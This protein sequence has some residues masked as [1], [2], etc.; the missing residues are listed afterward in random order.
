MS[1][2]VP[3]VLPKNREDLENKLERF[4]AIPSVTRIQIDVVDG[5]FATPKS[6]PYTESRALE[7]VAGTNPMSFPNHERIEYE[8]DLMCLDGERAAGQWLMLGASRL[9][10]HAEAILNLKSFF[11][12]V[13]QR[14]GRDVISYGLAINLATDWSLI[15]P[16]VEELSYVQCMGIETIGRQGQP[17]DKR[18]IEKIRA[19]HKQYPNIPVQ[20]DGGVSLATARALVEAGASN[21][22]VGSALM[23][24]SDVAQ[25]IQKFENLETPYAV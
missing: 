14:Y 13:G 8:I 12:T 4:A 3:A 11:A 17:F 2:V 25:E 15:E 9:T 6:W 23:R 16:V 1:L 18:V 21:L 24:A 10:F 20:V 7:V 19:F 22:I 5:R